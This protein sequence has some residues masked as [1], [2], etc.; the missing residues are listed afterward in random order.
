MRKE[1]RKERESGARGKRQGLENLRLPS[2][3]ATN[4]DVNN[5][6]CIFKNWT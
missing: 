4:D 2:R 3:L 6:S 5:K 1:E